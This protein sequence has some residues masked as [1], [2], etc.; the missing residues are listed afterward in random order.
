M[1]P[2]E[3]IAAALGVLGIAGAVQAF[4]NRAMNRNIDAKIAV[5]L[6]RLEDKQSNQIKSLDEHKATSSEQNRQ[7]LRALEE[8][9]GEFGKL[10]TRVAIVE[11]RTARILGS[12]PWGP[13]LNEKGENK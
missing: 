13:H 7:Q 9:R 1:S 3:I 8:M 10:T 6:S 11:D 2:N 5:P 12:G 4:G